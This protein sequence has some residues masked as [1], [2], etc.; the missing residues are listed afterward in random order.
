MGCIGVKCGH[1]LPSIGSHIQLL[2]DIVL[3]SMTESVRAIATSGTA[4][5]K[6][7]DGVTTGI[8]DLWCK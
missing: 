6:A 5:G 3:I 1:S 8:R 4:A 2:A 7:S